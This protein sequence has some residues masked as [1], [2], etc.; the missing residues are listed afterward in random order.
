MASKIG[1]LPVA[2]PGGVTVK[3][4]GDVISVKGPKGELKQKFN[5]LVKIDV[6]GSELVVNP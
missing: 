2:I 6:K 4:D 1:K 3:V 5:N